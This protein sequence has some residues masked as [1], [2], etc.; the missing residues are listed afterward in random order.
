MP[1]KDQTRPKKANQRQD[2]QPMT[3]K[4]GHVRE[5]IPN[6]GDLNMA[7]RRFIAQE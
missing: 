5:S 1:N 3:T 6:R 7:F 2:Q 4:P